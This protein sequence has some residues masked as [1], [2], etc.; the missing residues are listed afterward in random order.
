MLKKI[1]LTIFCL[2]LPF[3][4]LADELQLAQ[5]APTSYVVKKGDTLW[6]ISGVFLKEPWLWPKLWRIN[7]D[8]ENPHL[9]Y[10]GDELKLVFDAS[11]KPMLV[12]GKPKLK[13]SPKVRTALKDLNPVETIS[14]NVISS[15]IKYDTILSEQEFT[16]APYIIGSNEGYKLNVDG[17]KLYVNG[18][19]AVGQ[20]YAVYQKEEAILDLETGLIVGYYATLAGSGKA[21]KAGMSTEKKPATLYLDSAIREIRAGDI[22]KPVNDNQLLPGFFTMQAAAGSVSGHIIKAISGNREFGKQEVVFINRG[23]QH[24]VKQGDLF[25]VNRKSPAVV[26]SGSGPVYT[27]DA[28]RWNRMASASDSDYN[29]PEETVGKMMV[30]KVFDQISMALILHSTKPLRLQDSVTA[31]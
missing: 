8:I 14:L 2:S 4:S 17:L 31:P 1:I 24:G 10:P 18:D 22:V 5:N 21:I 25:S 15:L 13:W 27:S 30:Y 23:A 7:P 19:L 28:S 6:G 11:G 29:M 26:E 16:S 3:S 9:I 12:K 20:A